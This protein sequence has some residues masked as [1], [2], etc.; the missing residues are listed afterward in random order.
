MVA[1]R[2]AALGLRYEPALDGLR[3]ACLLAVLFFH[4]GFAWM[5]GGFLGVSTFFT[6][7]GFLITT[8]LTEEHDRHGTIAL[9]PFWDRRLRRLL[10][11]ALLTSAAIVVSAPL[12]LPA[13]QRERLAEDAL[14]TLLYVVNWQ[15]VGDAYA[16]SLIFTDPSPFQHFWSL[17]IEGQFYLV[18]PLAVALVLRL[19]G[20]V[21]ALA[22]LCALLVVASLAV[23]L[24]ASS[25]EA[26]Q[27]RLYYGTDARAAELLV[28]ALLALA[29]RRGGLPEV[30]VPARRALG[31]LAA[32]A[33]VLAWCLTG[34]GDA[35]LYRGGF[36]AYALLSAA[37]ID[38]ATGEAGAVRTLLSARWLRWIGTVSYGAYLFHWPLFLFLT[39][40]RT[41]LPEAPLFAVRAAATLGLAGLSYRFVEEPVRRSR[42]LPAPYFG[43]TA[44]ASLLAIALAAFALSPVPLAL[45]IAGPIAAVRDLLASDPAAATRVD[46]FAIFGDSTAMSLWKGLGPWLR[47]RPESDAAAGLTT[48]GCGVMVFGQMEN[49]GRWGTES[50]KCRGMPERW[51]RRAV[52]ERSDFAVVLVGPWEARTR[53]RAPGA[54]EVALGDPAM[55]AAVRE[56]ITDTVD[57][58]AA[59]ATGVV[60]LTSPHIRIPPLK[61]KLHDSD[62]EASAPERIDRLNEIIRD[63]GRTRPEAMRV[64]DLAAYMR[65]LPEGEFTEALRGD[66]VHFSAEGASR[67]SEV[68]LG[69][70]VLRAAAALRE[71]SARVAQ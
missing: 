71:T 62:R 35:W 66:G 53:R 47:Q 58:F 9:G 59:A 7:S 5:S 15:F 55:D 43:R 25:L 37:V 70:E 24:G 65:D 4:S 11:A 41:G 40:E 16:Y 68:W 29:R 18:F 12:W 19:S 1:T 2:P 26:A 44:L 42:L 64:V 61:G 54:P 63:V 57:A 49:R 34:V 33:I 20:S 46:R 36:A 39:S 31:A 23:S 10:P 52:A 28:G 38:A 13:A 14:A 56:A 30:A 51:A 32:V 3:G 67:V 27:H 60:W 69:P 45:R 17:A 22:W 6:L 21:R 8:L 50:D 48:L